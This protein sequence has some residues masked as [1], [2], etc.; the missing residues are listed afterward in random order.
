MQK[1]INRMYA[2]IKKPIDDNG[3]GLDDD[4][5]KILVEVIE[6]RSSFVAASYEEGSFPQ[7]FWK[8]Q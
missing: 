3:T 7:I 4:M 6:E 1:T 2:K 5:N 8:T